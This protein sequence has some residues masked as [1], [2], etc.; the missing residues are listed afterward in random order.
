MINILDKTPIKNIMEISS[1]A[2]ALNSM[3]GDAD[4]LTDDSQVIFMEI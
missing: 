1:V 2:G 3:T 4:D